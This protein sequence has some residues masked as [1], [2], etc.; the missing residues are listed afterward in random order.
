M[1]G[2]VLTRRGTSPKK[3]A[4]QSEER[5]PEGAENGEP[6]AGSLPSRTY[7]CLSRM[8]GRKAFSPMR[9]RKGR[10]RKKKVAK[11]KG[12]CR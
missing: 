12:V 10:G 5:P 6:D 4:S 11:E 9:R 8:S 1:A 2:K 3:A 7:G